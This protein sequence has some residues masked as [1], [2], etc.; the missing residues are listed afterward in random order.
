MALPTSHTVRRPGLALQVGED[1]LKI[2]VRV[3]GDDEVG[4]LARSLS[5]LASSR[6]KNASPGIT[7]PRAT[8]ARA[9]ST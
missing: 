9:C 4:H 8:E 6:L 7:S 1:V 2:G 5:S 3:L